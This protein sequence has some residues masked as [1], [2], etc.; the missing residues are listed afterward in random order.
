MSDEHIYWDHMPKAV[1]DWVRSSGWSREEVKQVDINRL[2]IDAVVDNSQ[3]IKYIPTHYVYVTVRSRLGAHIEKLFDNSVDGWKIAE[4]G[5]EKKQD[6]ARPQFEK[7]V[8]Y[9]IGLVCDDTLDSDVLSGFLCKFA[10]HVISNVGCEDLDR[11]ETEEI[12][13]R[14]PDMDLIE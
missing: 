8:L 1:K 6:K 3:M 11:L 5:K 14:I 13:Q 2:G 10:E 4:F 12:V 9:I 7:A